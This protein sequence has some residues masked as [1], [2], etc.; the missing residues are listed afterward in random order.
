MKLSVLVILGLR[1][2]AQ[3]SIEGQPFQIH[4]FASEG[5]AYSNDNNYLTMNTMKG[6]FAF[7]DAGLN[8]STQVTDKFRVGAQAYLRNVGEL[9][10][11]HVTLDWASG[12]Y[13]FNNWL[14]IRAGKVK[15]V[16]GLYNDTQ[17]EE[18]LY[19]WALL[20]QSLYPVDLRETSIA[21]VGADLYGT[22]SL[23]KFGD[24]AYTAYAG[25]LPEDKS[26]GYQYGLQALGLVPQKI[27]GHAEG[28]DLK[29]TAPLPGL[30]LGASFLNSPRGA[31]A[32]NEAFG[33]P[34]S[35]NVFGDHRSVFS[36]QYTIGNF[37][38]EGE[39]SR[40][41]QEL[42]YSFA[43]PTGSSEIRLDFDE[44]AWY[45]A[46]AYRISK[47]LELGTYNSRFFPNAGR[48][49]LAGIELPPAAR[50][51]FDQV[52]T[53]R[54]DLTRFWDFKIEGHFIDG[55]GDPTSFRGFYPQDN[56]A[57]FQPRTNLLILRMGVNF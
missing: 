8:L 15:T 45:A 36:G 4:G 12:D 40:E 51:I 35:V 28:A 47:H 20:P 44:R 33:T 21:H 24:L 16:L 34:E 38:V 46:I 1:L 6:S 54:I 25:Q 55:Y 18:F 11:G 57:G 49:Q 48:S 19:T 17:D 56:P 13:R 29:W 42:N 27:S 52:V 22:V 5:F 39:Y 41:L 7:T 26:G 31:Q 23:R 3:V 32:F 53:A 37:H 14:G 43:A 2:S 50:H 30:V 9:G 10:H